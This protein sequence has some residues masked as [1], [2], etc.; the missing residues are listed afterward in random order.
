ME[1]AFGVDHGEI[2]KLDDSR[3]AALLGPL[4][5]AGKAKKGMGGKAYRTQYG[6]SAVGAGAGAGVGAAIG[7]GAGA[8]ARRPGLGAGIG[9]IGGA[10]VGSYHGGKSGYKAVKSKGYLRDT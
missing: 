1:S 7:A 9:A 3:K 2:S 8:L 5:T 10:S 6:H 4:Y